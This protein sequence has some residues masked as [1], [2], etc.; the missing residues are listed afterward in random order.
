MPKA[1]AAVPRTTVKASGSPSGCLDEIKDQRRAAI[2]SCLA[3]R[4]SYRTTLTDSW[5]QG[6]EADARAMAITAFRGC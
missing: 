3:S 1:L 5:R 4:I 2:R 6:C